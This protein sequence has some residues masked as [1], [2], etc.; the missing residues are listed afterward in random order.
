MIT[1]L[2]LA[3]VALLAGAINALAGGGQ[4]MVFPAL[5]FAGVASVKANATSSLVVL[6]GVAASAW[7]YRDTTKQMTGRFLA[8]MVLASLAGSAVASW[9][10]MHTTNATFSRL[11]PWLL[12]LA[13]AVFSAAPQ[14]RKL[15]A[16]MTGGRVHLP[17]LCAGQFAI[18]GYGGYF[19]AGM[20][21]LML[22]LYLALA[23]LEL[24]AASGLR[25]FCAAFINTL[26]V[27]IFAARGALD[28]RL[29][30]PML[31][32][33]VA[34]GYLGAKAVQRLDAGKV[35]LGVLFYAWGL[36]AYFFVRAAI[37]RA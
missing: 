20:G 2:V 27:M 18:A 5:L 9:L 14:L 19:G 8:C 6:P 35:R 16:S 4:F 26:A 21:V 25:T 31:F 33:A 37:G 15:G 12:L 11:V 23:H 22:A 32:A 29:G 17:V 7:V 10:L 13:A 1:I 3:G 30:V 34:G 36:T 28:Y 24:H